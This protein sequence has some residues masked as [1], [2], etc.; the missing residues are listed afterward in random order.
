MGGQMGGQMPLMMPTPQLQQPQPP[1]IQMPGI[2]SIS[3]P[4]PNLPPGMQQVIANPALMG[5]QPLPLPKLPDQNPTSV[6]PSYAG[7]N[8]SN[9]SATTTGAARPVVHIKP[10]GVAVDVPWGWN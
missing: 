10:P 4:L 2:A 7:F 8:F 9:S 5:A 6:L 1:Q 3:G